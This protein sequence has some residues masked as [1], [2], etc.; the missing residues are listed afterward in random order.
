MATSAAFA[1]AVTMAP[2]SSRRPRAASTLLASLS[3]MNRR[4]KGTPLSCAASNATT[5]EPGRYVGSTDSG[6][7]GT[8]KQINIRCFRA[9]RVLRTSVPANLDVLL[10]DGQL[11]P[12]PRADLGD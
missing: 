5:G 2:L 7:T 6:Q 11:V 8:A 9:T 12:C 10:E 4:L 1:T 3:E